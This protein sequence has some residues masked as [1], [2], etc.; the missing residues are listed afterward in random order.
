MRC[1]EY[2]LVAAVQPENETLVVTEPAPLDEL[3]AQALIEPVCPLVVGHR[4]DEYAIYSRIRETA[5]P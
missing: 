5:V 2:G 4:V 3:E 1:A